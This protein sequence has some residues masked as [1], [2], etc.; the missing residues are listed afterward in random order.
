MVPEAG[1]YQRQHG[2]RG[3]MVTGTAWYQRQHGTRGSMVSEAAWYQR[4]HGNRDSM[5]SEAAWYQRQHGIG[6]SMVSEAAYAEWYTS[7]STTP[8]SLFVILHNA[9]TPE[10]GS[11]NSVISFRHQRDFCAPDV[12]HVKRGSGMREG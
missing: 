9:V 7:H 11:A 6:G 12:C 3:S 4:Q 1:W 5:V 2:I 8:P 10:S